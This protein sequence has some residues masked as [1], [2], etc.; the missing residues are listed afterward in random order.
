MEE[1]IAA[2]CI[3]LDIG[4]LVEKDGPL[5]YVNSRQRRYDYT[6]AGFL[7]RMRLGLNYDKGLAE[8]GICSGRTFITWWGETFK[9]STQQ[10]GRKAVSGDDA[11]VRK[12]ENLAAHDGSTVQDKDDK[13]V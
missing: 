2:A 12:E 5:A 3:G 11:K 13:I 4:R 1:H 7:K 9:P 8:E 10:I 6:M